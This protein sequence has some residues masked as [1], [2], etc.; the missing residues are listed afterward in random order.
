MFPGE[1]IGRVVYGWSSSKTK[2]TI[3]AKTPGDGFVDRGGS[4]RL[5]STYHSNLV[6]FN[7]NSKDILNETIFLCA[8]FSHIF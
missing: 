4:V 1:Y 2:Q 6:L 8:G 5:K 3:T 7:R